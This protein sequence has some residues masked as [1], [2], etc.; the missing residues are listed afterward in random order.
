M[1]DKIEEPKEEIVR[2]YIAIDEKD[3]D[4]ICHGTKDQVE[5]IIARE[6]NEG[7]SIDDITVYKAVKAFY[8]T[9]NIKVVSKV[10]IKEK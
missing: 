6:I 7:I 1:P 10:V 2:N 3:G 5:R 9:E 4:L 8:S